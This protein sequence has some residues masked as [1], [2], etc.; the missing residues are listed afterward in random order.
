MNLGQ[1]DCVMNDAGGEKLA[2]IVPSTASKA[3][4]ARLRRVEESFEPTV[5]CIKVLRTG[6]EQW[7]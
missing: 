6:V 5:P 1:I 4:D 3:T 2:V 7:T